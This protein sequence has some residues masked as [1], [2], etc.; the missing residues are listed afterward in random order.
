[1][2]GA[3]QSGPAVDGQPSV[4]RAFTYV[5]NGAAM[6]A[7]A[8]VTTS[9]V[10]GATFVLLL[11]ASQ[12]KFAAARTYFLQDLLPTFRFQRMGG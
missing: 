6:E 8:L 3:T 7:E 4:E 11:F 12:V 1:V 2:A 9:R 5:A 10:S